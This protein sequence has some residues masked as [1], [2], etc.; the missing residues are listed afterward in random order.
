MAAVDPSQPSVAACASAVL[1]ADVRV[2]DA[3]SLPFPDGG[4]DV[5]LCQLVVNFMADA[6]L[7]V[8]PMRRVTR[9]GGT[10][11][12]CTRDDRDGMTMLRAFWDAAVVVDP[13]GRT[14]DA[15]C[16]S[17]PLRSSGACGTTSAWT[18]R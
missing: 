1:D 15:S 16:R 8:S 18:R 7:G 11:A 9:P 10:V 13:A 6:R 12:A 3:E 4:F 5:S 2:G 17:A 14:K